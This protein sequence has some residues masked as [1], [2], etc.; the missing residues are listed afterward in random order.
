MQFLKHLELK[1]LF[2]KV[3]KVKQGSHEICW[4]RVSNRSKKP[5]T[6]R[7]WHISVEEGG[8]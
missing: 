4:G 1:K 3:P 8:Q 6:G 7:T 2:Q 5:G